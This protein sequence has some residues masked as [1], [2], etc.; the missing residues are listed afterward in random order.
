ASLYDDKGVYVGR[1]VLSKRILLEAGLR[2][3]WNPAT[4]VLVTGGAVPGQEMRIMLPII[5]YDGLPEHEVLAIL[6][7]ALE[8][9]QL[10]AQRC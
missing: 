6:R 1:S 4:M 5:S 9:A 10:R 3:H 2:R 7:G 8:I